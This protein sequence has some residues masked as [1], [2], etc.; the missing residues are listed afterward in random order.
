MLLIEMYALEAYLENVKKLL[1][2][3]AAQCSFFDLAVYICYA[4]PFTN[5]NS[6]F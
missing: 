3:V 4:N 1:T 6:S 5:V 2:T